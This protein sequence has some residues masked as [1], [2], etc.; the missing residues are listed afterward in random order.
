MKKLVKK[1]AALLCMVMVFGA[2]SGCGS[3]PVAEEFETF[4]NENMVDVNANYEKLKAEVAKWANFENDA[5]YVDSINNVLLPNVNESLEM[6]SKIEVQT[7]E[8]NS[9]KAK[10]EDML[11][12][13]KESFT[14]LADACLNADVAGVEAATEKMADA[15]AL[16]EVYNAALEELAEEKGL[17]VEY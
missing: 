2:C 7:E 12:T 17:T 13:Y 10:Y 6:L 9:I 5:Q 16:L 8:V 3:D 15:V 14:M 11:N 1:V 4:M